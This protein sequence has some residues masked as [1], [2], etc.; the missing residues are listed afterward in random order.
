MVVALALA[1][2]EAPLNL[3]QVDA[4]RGEQ[5]RRSDQLQAVA[6]NGKSAV[7]VG[8]HGLLLQSADGGSSWQRR[9]LPGWPSLI[10]ATACPDGRMA[11]LSF[12][13]RVWSSADGGAV[14]AD[15][16]L[17]GDQHPQ[18]MT[19]AADN[20]L[21]VVGSFG[22]IWTSG[23]GGR[24]WTSRSDGE[25]VIYTDIMFVDGQ[26]GYIVGEFGVV[27]RTSDGG[28]NWEPMTPLP[29]DF[30]SQAAWFRN[31]DEGWVVGL[32]GRVY[33]TV[34]GAETWSVQEAATQAPLYGIAG[35]GDAIFIV[36]GAGT[37]LRLTGDKWSVVDHGLPVRSYLRAVSPLGAGG[38]LVAGGGGALHRY[39]PPAAGAAP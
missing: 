20:T 28:E 23:D 3:Q 16:R 24:T 34:D 11:V 22:T 1:A 9:E 14:W 30:Y 37:V 26:A 25:D 15:V 8:A 21:W 38:W 27:M 12:E 17:E 2:C 19:C 31:A 39:V 32:S 36:G 7:A 13:G 18:A 35:A 33:H 5:I 10:D 6:A 4:A 29:D